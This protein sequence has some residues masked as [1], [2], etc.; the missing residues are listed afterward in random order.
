MDSNHVIP[1]KTGNEWVQINQGVPDEI[2]H[3]TVQQQQT[4]E[5]TVNDQLNELMNEKAPPSVQ[6]A[7][8]EVPK[9]PLRDPNEDFNQKV[10]ELQIPTTNGTTANE[11]SPG[12]AQT[13]L[14]PDKHE[15]EASSTNASAPTTSN[16]PENVSTA[17]P[18]KK[19]KVKRGPRGPY[20]KKAKLDEDFDPNSKRKTRKKPAKKKYT[21]SDE[22]D[23]DKNDDNYIGQ[24]EEDD[25]YDENATS[26]RPKRKKPSGKKTTVKKSVSFKPA[27]PS[28]RGPPKGISKGP[29]SDTESV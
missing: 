15:E 8:G 11:A 17:T 13:P 19:E 10:L 3:E 4:V 26:S 5:Q 29:T 14:P 21:F 6:Q 7:R 27:V 20:K 28:K 2:V 1:Q 12:A 16:L 24:Q 18:E 23:D 25:D 9:T 22:D